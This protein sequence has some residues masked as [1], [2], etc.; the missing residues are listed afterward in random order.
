MK[1]IIYFMAIF[2]SITPILAHISEKN[3]ITAVFYTMFFIFIL[4]P[5]IKKIMSKQKYD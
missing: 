1:K 3:Y 5:F 2:V 4:H